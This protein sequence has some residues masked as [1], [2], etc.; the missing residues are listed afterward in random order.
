MADTN[1][2]ET[3]TETG[4]FAVGAASA[5]SDA[6]D[7]VAMTS[8][9]DQATVSTKTSKKRSI[10][11]SEATLSNKTNAPTIAKRRFSLLNIAIIA[12]VIV[13]I[14]VVILI[15]VLYASA[16]KDDV[17]TD[18]ASK[19][20]TQVASEKDAGVY[21]DENTVSSAAHTPIAFGELQIPQTF[22][23]NAFFAVSNTNSA[24]NGEH[25]S[26][27]NTQNAVS[28]SAN[29]NS[30]AAN[31]SQDF[32]WVT[33]EEFAKRN[34]KEKIELAAQMAQADNA[35][36]GILPSLTIA[37]FILE[38]GWGKSA[39]ASNYEN[40]FG[41][42]KH[43]DSWANSTWPGKSVDYETGEEYDGQQVRI[44]DSFRAYDNAW[45][46]FQDHSAYLANRTTSGTTKLYAGI[47]G[48][49]SI[50]RCCDILVAG[51][52]ATGS[53]Y[54]ASIMKLVQEYNLTQYD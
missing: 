44:I 51:G 39:L 29:E 30:S 47:V 20:A 9:T 32:S 13:L 24:L 1:M 11:S 17:S 33:N 46:S 21:I 25:P 28:T 36:S 19:N 6:T 12:C 34:N 3:K 10:L 54:K 26:S 18:D 41:I 15:V 50:S 49:K 22:G 23:G 16:A 2:T 48:E 45:Q 5:K 8:K 38:S 31:V 14:I 40:Y 27:S 43:A 4:D 42:K 35:T 52:Y 37:Q 53:S 7:A